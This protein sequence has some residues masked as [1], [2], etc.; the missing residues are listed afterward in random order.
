[1]TDIMIN[2]LPKKVITTY[3]LGFFLSN[4]SKKME[5]LLCALFSFT[6]SLVFQ[7][8]VLIHIHA[9]FLKSY[10]YIN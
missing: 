2:I 3:L 8:L 10:T 5:L 7:F 6:L 9:S 1:M 4:K